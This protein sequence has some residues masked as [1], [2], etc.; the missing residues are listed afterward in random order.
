MRDILFISHANPEDNA[1]AE[2]LA[3]QLAC[4]GYPV[5]C[6][7]TRLLG[8][9]DFWTDIEKAIRTRAVKFLFVLSRTS[10]AKPGVLKELQVAENVARDDKLEHFILPLAVDD[11]PPRQA[12]IGVTRLTSLSFSPSWARGL[13]QLLKRLE[14]DGVSKAPQFGPDSVTKWWRTRFSSS[15]GVRSQPEQLISNW[16][17]ILGPIRLH[18]HTLRYRPSPASGV[19][20]ISLPASLPWHCVSKDPYLVSFA[21]ASA[22]DGQLGPS[23]SIQGGTILE[24]SQSTESARRKFWTEEEERAGLAELLA[25]SWNQMVQTRGLSTYAFSNRGLAFYFVDG[26]AQ[27]NRVSFRALHDGSA[28]Y[29]QVVGFKTVLKAAPG[30]APRLRY[31]H[32]ALEARPILSPSLGLTIKP[33]L[34]FSDDGRVLWTSKERMHKAGRSQRRNWWNDDW[35]DRIIGSMA[36]LAQGGEYVALPTSA[37]EELAVS[38]LPLQFECPLSLDEDDLEGPPLEKDFFDSEEDE[39]AD[40]DDLD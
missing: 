10:N 6:D 23:I 12:N 22:L 17:P 29:R 35:R 31:W 14:D 30:S 24:L 33:H 7:L 26:T 20:P 37:D 27:E 11:L 9:E 32:F 38:R 13:A 8:G 21:P 2:W 5:W 3:L 39:A 19:G 15:M 16:F 25:A 40:A 18:F 28:R 34:L 36:W 4:A 1:F